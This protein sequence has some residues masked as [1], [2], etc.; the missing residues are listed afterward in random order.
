MKNK[1]FIISF[2]IAFS[3]KYA[4]SQ[5][6]VIDSLT[7]ILNSLQG[8]KKIE[9]LLSLSNE[10]RPD[11]EEKAL[12]YA[13][14][15]TELATKSNNKIKILE[16]KICEAKVHLKYG[17]DKKGLEL[18]E[19]VM[20]EALAIKANEAVAKIYKAKY[21]YYLDVKAD[22]NA[23]VL[24]MDKAIAFTTA[25]NMQVL[26]G[27]MYNKRGVA[28]YYLGNLEMAEKDF[29]S[30][31][32]I[33]KNTGDKAEEAGTI[34]N[35]GVVFFHS[36]DF[37]KSIEYYEK[38]LKVFEQLKDT[39]QIAKSL[40]NIAMTEDEMGLIKS[41]KVKLLKASHY[42]NIAHDNEGLAGSI[43]NI[44]NIFSKEGKMDS[45]LIYA[46]KVLKIRE[47][48][49]SEKL[50]GTSYTNI[51]SMYNQLNQT[52]IA[53]EYINKSIAQEEKIGNK[54]KQAD[55]ISF[56]GAIYL[57]AN[58]Y[59]EAE[60]YYQEALSMREVIGNKKALSDSYISLGN[61][62]QALQKPDKALEYYLKAL[63]I[64]E[65]MGDRPSI[66]GITN[67]IGVLYYDKKD[68]KRSIEYYLKALELRKEIG[69][70]NELG[71]SYLT[72]SNS[73]KEIKNFENAYKF[74]VLYS[75]INDS[76]FNKKFA[77]SISEMQAK[78]ETDKQK[79]QI[80]LLEKDQKISEEEIKRKNT[81]RNALAIGGILVLGLLFFAVRGYMQKQKDNKL[82]SQQK[83]LVEQKSALVEEKQKEIIDSINY[84]K[85]LQ[86][87]ILPAPEL[88]QK[89]LPHNFI[90]YKPKDIVAGD[91]YWMYEN[92][93]MV[94]MAA[95]D[96]T[97]H[98]VPGALVSIVCSNA[99]DKAVKEFSLRD[100]G[101]I[102]DKTTDLVLETFDKSGEEIKDGMDISLICFDKKNKKIFWSGANN[103]LLYVKDKEL[104]VIRADKQ[105][106]GKSDHRQA[107]TT[108]QI[109]YKE[110]TT[111]Y[112]MTD[113]LA[114]QFGGPK[115][116]KFMYK[117][118]EE[119]ILTMS[120]EILSL[121][122][123]ILDETFRS[124]KGELE[125]LDDITIIGIKI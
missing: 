97:G 66:A 60:K 16:G 119:K 43:E 26:L 50:I 110:G 58:N 1:I 4:I 48:A 79:Q 3:F 109:D 17:K 101:K 18:I 59:A 37:K 113:G 24:M 57:R 98:G 103:Q 67:N 104:N 13:L 116:K 5:N 111:F 94:F 86:N 102:L 62:H 56:K 121:Q 29:L 70:I 14:E 28:Y 80:G 20:N 92:E 106:V 9:A 47:E 6:K 73:Y 46:F 99:L 105:P 51:A 122:K 120:G 34:M 8:E 71:E 107:F 11:S 38:A 27:D 91:F 68:Y 52:D 21:A 123:T 100:T 33:R 89:H 7:P 76:T 112:L 74:H 44:S 41:A 23:S 53:L 108:H 39:L 72:L 81:Q 30:C 118:L 96:S 15:A 2:L 115:G 40:V 93:Q 82:I 45:A 124:W 49:R 22:I 12:K 90:F 125:Q 65:E 77:A 42:Y 117:K 95:A 85:R 55:R 31:V 36:G 63:K 75:N 87:A 10:H 25:N 19:D 64:K 35:I 84:A 83:E 88:I 78:Y 54:T 32:A 61:L 114:D 69:D